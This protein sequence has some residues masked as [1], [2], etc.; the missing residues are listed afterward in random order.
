MAAGPVASTRTRAA[1]RS[2]GHGSGVAEHR[3][4]GRRGSDREMGRPRSAATAAASRSARLGSAAGVGARVE[5][6]PRG[7]GSPSAPL[8]GDP[9]LDI[10]RGLVTR[11]STLPLPAVGPGCG[12]MARRRASRARAT[13]GSPAP[14]VVGHP[15]DGPAG[16]GD[17][18]HRGVGVGVVE[19]AAT[20]SCSWSRSRSVARPVARWSSTRAAVSTARGASRTRQ[21]DVGEQGRGGHAPRR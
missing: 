10:D 14:D 19:A 8:D 5:R 18:G 7:T 15:G 20:W 1:R 4:P 16:F 12:T 17:G 3:P 6:R 2:S 13:T 21:V 11:A 9:G